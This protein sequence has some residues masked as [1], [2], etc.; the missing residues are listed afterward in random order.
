MFSTFDWMYIYE[1]LPRLMRGLGM[2]LVVSAVSIVLS[3]LVGLGGAWCRTRRNPLF[4]MAG[5]GYV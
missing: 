5:A 2:T 1:M 3:L 4:S